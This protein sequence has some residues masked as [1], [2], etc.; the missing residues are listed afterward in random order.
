MKSGR[1]SI[2][3]PCYKQA[4]FI[5]ETLDSVLAQTYPNWE[6]VIV[7]DGSPDNTEEIANRYVAKDSRFK[8]VWIENGGPSQARNVGIFNSTGEYV[9][10]LDADDLIA[11]TYLEKAVNCF[12]QVQETKLV[13]C[14]VDKFGKENGNWDLETYDYEKFIWRNC[15]F[16]TAMFR[17]ADYDQTHGYNVNMVHGNEDWDFWLTLLKKDD[18]VYRIDEVLFHY[19]IKDKSR[20]TELAKHHV[21]ESLIQMCKNHPEIYSPY[22]NWIFDYTDKKDEVSRLNCELNQIRSSRAYRLGKF[23]LK[24][25]TWIRNKR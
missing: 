6:C 13:Y 21:E 20:T 19:R 7:N 10:P 9:L 11:S 15:I 2:V 16:C 4:E 8:Y 18:V 25:L 23:L 14:K 5:A 17:R 12:I 3:V 1:V 22:Y 24:P